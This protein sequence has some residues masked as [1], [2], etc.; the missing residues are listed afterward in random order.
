MID[1]QRVKKSFNEF[2]NNYNYQDP[3]FNLKVVHTMHVVENAK[4]IAEH[5]QLSDE[6]YWICILAFVFDLNFKETFDVIKDNNYVD[7]LIDKFKYTNK[8]TSERM[9]KIRSIINEY[10]REKTN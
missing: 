1:L 5:M 8:I 7:V 10:V 9:E 3:G 6:D 4:G 2:I